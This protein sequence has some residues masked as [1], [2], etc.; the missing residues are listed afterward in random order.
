MGHKVNR[1]FAVTL[2]HIVRIHHVLADFEQSAGRITMRTTWAIGRR[3]HRDIPR[4]VVGHGDGR[5]LFRK[6]SVGQF[7]GNIGCIA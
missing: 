5:K 4:R 7:M 1:S 2:L 6:S 3:A